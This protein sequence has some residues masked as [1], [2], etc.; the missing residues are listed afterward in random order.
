MVAEKRAQ[1]AADPPTGERL[2]EAARSMAPRIRA[3]ADEIERARRLPLPLVTELAEA[4]IFRSLA[5]RAIGGSE[6]DPLSWMEIIETLSEADASVGW[7]AAIGSGT[8]FSTG[9]L[10]PDIGYELVGRDPTAVMGGSGTPFGQA[11]VVEGGYRV[12]GRWP[13]ASGCEHARWLIG[14]S[15]IRDGETPRKDDNGVPVMRIMIFPSSACT[16]LDT[17]YVGGLRGSGSH[18]FAVSDVFV[19]EERSFSPMEASS[20]HDGLLYSGRFF[21]FLFQHAAHALG[22]ARA[23]IDAL[24]E[25]ANRK[26]FGRTGSLLRDRP[27]VRLQIAQAEALVRSAR[28]WAWDIARETWDQAGRS[29]ALTLE[30]GALARLAITN[31]VVKSAEAVDLMYSAA[32]GSAVYASNRLERAFR[33]I[34]TVTQHVIVAPPSYEQVGEALAGSDRQRV[35]PVT[36]LRLF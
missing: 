22:V 11:T 32:G 26:P 27:M 30:Q 2:V 36:G 7:C 34:H 1:L 14:N 33:D 17:W 25:L 3:C 12:T 20:Y 15:V 6:L 13:F 35:S 31:A 23:A 9:F 10:R 18:D 21:F 24:V 29:Q 8:A 28:A 16:I 4:G 5:P 19:P